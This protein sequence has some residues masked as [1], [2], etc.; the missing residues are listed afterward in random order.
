MGPPV[1]IID[2]TRDGSPLVEA[3]ALVRSD[4]GVYFLSF[5]SGCTRMPSYDFKYA[6]STKIN[7]PYLQTIIDDGGLEPSSTGQRICKAR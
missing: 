5:S 1:D 2:S 4:E 3:P 7:G 6:T